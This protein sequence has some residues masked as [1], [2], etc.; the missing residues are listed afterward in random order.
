[1]EVL[2]TLFD[3]RAHNLEIY[4]QKQIF[5]RM[6]I[7]NELPM[8]QNVAGE[9]TNMVASSNPDKLTGDPITTSEG[10]NFSEIK[11]GEPSELKGSTK[12]KGFMFRMSKRV[13]DRGRLESTL[14]IFIN[15]SI[16]RLIN[17]YDDVFMKGLMAGSGAPAPDDLTPISKDITGF[18]ILANEIKIKDAMEFQ[19]D[20]DTGFSPNKMY[21]NRQDA[22]Y[23]KLALTESGLTDESEFEYVPTTRLP[24]GTQVA[25]DTVNPTA[26]IEKYADPDYSILAKFEAE[27]ENGRLY[28]E[29]GNPVPPSF[30]NIKI[31]EP[32]EPQRSNYYIFTEAGLNVMEPS[33]I[34][35]IGGN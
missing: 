14:Q 15:K 6:A 28:D 16:G 34:M 7:L 23:V 12:P 32:D 20:N 5:N 4:A 8:N 1:M 3:E 25:R 2:P 31:S 22:L 21:L 10:V 11:F 29:E 26:T 35:T 9:F 17:Y 33:G 27:S 18:E 30:I 13:A 19:N 24:A